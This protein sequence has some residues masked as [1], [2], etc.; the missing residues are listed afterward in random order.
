MLHCL[1]CGFCVA[2]SFTHRLPVRSAVFLTAG[3]CLP[4][5]FGG[6]VWGISYL[7]ATGS[8]SSMA[9]DKDVLRDVW[10]GRIPTCFTLNQDE[11]TEREAEPYYVSAVPL[12]PHLGAKTAARSVLRD[13]PP[14]LYPLSLQLFNW[15]LCV[16]MNLQTYQITSC[17][18][19][20]TICI[21]YSSSAGCMQLKKYSL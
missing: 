16:R 17:L 12:W 15:H 8:R 14:C 20:H 2:E 4:L 6:C 9:D 5:D 3:R 10:F 21:P 13:R 18:G 1:Q 19:K 7:C 11:V